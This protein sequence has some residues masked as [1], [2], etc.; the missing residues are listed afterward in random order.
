MSPNLRSSRQ[1]KAN[2]FRSRRKT[3]VDQR[4]E[5]EA[6]MNDIEAEMLDKARNKANKNVRK[7]TA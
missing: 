4:L 7:A 5:A 1:S 3:S 2:S 6:E